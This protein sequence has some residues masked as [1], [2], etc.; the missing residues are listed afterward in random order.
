MVFGLYRHRK[1]SLYL[2][3]CTV[4]HSETGEAMVLYIGRTGIYVRPAAMF[5]DGRFTRVV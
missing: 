5:L 3:I 4:K 2:A 1:G